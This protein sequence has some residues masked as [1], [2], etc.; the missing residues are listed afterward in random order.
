M[1]PTRKEETV[2]KPTRKKGINLIN[3]LIAEGEKTVKKLR[4]FEHFPVKQSIC[5]ICRT[6]EDGECILVPIAASNDGSDNIFEAL[7]THTACLQN[8]I[9]YP[10]LKLI[11][12]EAVDT[13]GLGDY[14]KPTPEKMRNIAKLIK[15]E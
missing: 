12:V 6:S 10:D 4:T 2:K 3:S 1:K 9:F 15:G 14:K 8:L 5:P 13:R 11:L 7:P